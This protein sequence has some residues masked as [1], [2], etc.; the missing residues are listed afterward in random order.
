MSEH[1][2]VFQEH[3]QLQSLGINQASIGFNKLTMESEKFICVRES[4]NDV[5]SV[6]IVDLNDLGNVIRRSISADSAIMHPM[7]KVIALKAEREL[8]VFDLE[9]KVKLASCQT[10]DTVVFWKWVSSTKL[11]LV[12]ET[13]CYLWTVDP[14][15]LSPVKMFDRN[16]VLQGAQ[17]INFRVNQ[18]ETWM[19]VI[20]I[21]VH[22][23]RVVGNIQLFNTVKCASQMIE[24]HAA[25]FAEIK[26]DAVPIHLFAFAARGE[27]GAKLHLVEIDPSKDA[28]ATT[29]NQ[30]GKKTVEVF[31]AP[32][33]V[34]DFPVSMQVSKKY[35]VVFLIT[36]FGFVHLYDLETATCIYM[37]RISADTV[38]VTADYSSGMIGVNRKGQVLSV[39]VDEQTIISYVR[40]S[41]KNPDLALRLA[42]RCG[43]PGADDMYLHVF[44]QHFSSGNYS[45][46][47]KIAAKSP[48]GILRTPSIVERIRQAPTQRGQQASPMLQYFACLLERGSLNKFETLELSKPILQQN[49]VKMLENWIK[50]NKLFLCEELGDL[51]KPL[52]TELALQVYLKSNEPQKVIACYAE[53]N[54]F[55][56]ILDYAQKSNYNVDWLKILNLVLRSNPEK[57]VEFALKLKEQNISV[58]QLF[59]CFLNLKLIPQATGFMLDVLKENLPIHGNLQTKVLEINLKHS[60]QVADAILGNNMFSHYDKAQIAMLCESAGLYQRALEHY[61]DIYDIKRTLIHTHLLNPEWVVSYFG[62]LSVDQSHECLKEML[63]SNLRQNLHICVQVAVKYSEQL[64]PQKLILLFENL[65]CMEGLY[66]YLGAIVNQSQ[67][68]DVHFKYI[69][70]AC[71]TNQQKE[72]ERMCQES[73]YFDPEKVKNFL[74]ESNLQDMLPLIIVCDRFDF[75]QDLVLFL[76]KNNMFRFI[77]VYVQKVNPSRAPLVLGALMDINCD[78]SIIKQLLNQIRETDFQSL[79]DEMDKRNRLKLLLPFIEQ[80]CKQSTETCLFNALAKI[81]IDSN[82]NAELFLTENK[83][84]DP[85]IVGKYCEKRNP[86]LAFVAYKQGQ[87]DDELVQITNKESMFK[88]QARYIV[89]RKEKL[90]WL[91]VLMENPFR[92]SLIDSVLVV[93][94]E[95]QDS[96]EVSTTVKAFMEAKL[97]PELIEL[98]EKIVLENSAFNDN[99]YLQN[100]L[101][102]TAIQC[103][104]SKV[105]DY[106]NKLNNFNASQI[107]GVAIA[108]QLYEEAFTIYK[109]CQV[110]DLAITVL[111]ENIKDLHRA[112]EFALRVDQMEVWS[113]LA[114]SQLNNNMTKESILSYIRIKDPSNYLQVISVSKQKEL[115]LDLL[116]FLKMA[117]L[118][119]REQILETELLYCLAKTDKVIDLEEFLL[120]PHL[121]DANEVGDRCLREKLYPAAKILFESVSNWAKLATALVNLKDYTLAVECAKKANSV[122]VWRS[123]FE[124]CLKNLEFKLSHMCGQNL[125]VHADE[126]EQ[127]C[128]F[129]ESYGHF[130]QLIQLLEQSLTL[131]RT[132]MGIFTEL[133]ICYSKYSSEKLGDHIKLNWR[134]LNIPKVIRC[135]EQAELWN[136]LVFLYI[137]NE[138]WDNAALT[139]I[140][141]SAYFDHTIFKDILLKTRNQTVYY[142]AIKFYLDEH[143]LLINDV[144]IAISP[145]IDHSRVIQE[146][147]KSKNIPLCKPY[148]VSALNLNNSDVSQAY[149]SLLI[150]ENDYEGLKRAIDQ[151][152]NFDVLCLAQ[153]LSTHKM[154]EFRRIASH[155]YKKTKRFRN[156]IELSKQ[157][158]QYKDAMI[159]AAESNDASIVEDL[160]DFFCEHDLKDCFAAILYNCYSLLKPDVV[161][162]IAWRKNWADAA[163]PYTIQTFRD[164]SLKLDALSLK[165]EKTQEEP[166]PQQLM[167]PYSI[168]K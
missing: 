35:G 68:P 65:K 155:L 47:V 86:Y 149:H 78:D 156:S 77:E 95:S 143:P 25:T 146:I 79:I 70:A 45:E 157:D 34:A 39:T 84:Y 103:D 15:A 96:D 145:R 127:V 73:N 74:K 144:L 76:F 90:L 137:H 167:I 124:V 89:K 17:I 23:G 105:M 107:A 110:N 49:R 33:A 54:R 130:Q 123:L 40:L 121:G 108:G 98:L 151:H 14:P 22:L 161:M 122:K 56:D 50:E 75:V 114:K 93:L 152:G 118:K 99:E 16:P 80:K 85:R 82:N 46:A 67:D 166:N 8:Q 41:L 66:Y 106:I 59:D 43:L 60:P 168:Q 62:R 13:A 142:R 26:T 133:A 31:F 116:S 12:T 57:G 92:R 9:A 69:Q 132:H 64:T 119:L 126:L 7:K 55:N 120:T 61:T 138:E 1:P 10:Q 51:I 100:L 148:L 140:M 48:N 153:K 21:A 18:A 5:N 165:L 163:L 87:C 19:F 141:H 164:F 42:S 162:E 125:I 159:C 37:N 150:E 4:I 53:T 58:V 28:Q 129:Y 20:G 135:V 117:R 44:E 91:N 72:V 11:G 128:R 81:Y 97:H 27:S 136:Q 139:M 104:K 6:V 134:R 101:I 24:G 112:E 131:E 88:Q 94:P 38:F 113:L 115:Y 36:K 63:T 160:L 2:I 154:M 111:T 109:R 52:D 158:L 32:E 83:F 3:V 71:K 29:L 30:Y 102:L 147:T